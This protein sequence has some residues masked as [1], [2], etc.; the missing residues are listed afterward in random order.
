MNGNGERRNVNRMWWLMT[1]VILLLVV[2]YAANMVL[3]DECRTEMRRGEDRSVRVDNELRALAW[4]CAQEV[5]VP[6]L[7]TPETKLVRPI[8]LV[9]SFRDSS[10]YVG[11]HIVVPVRVGSIRENVIGWHLGKSDSPAAI[12][13]QFPNAI[14][15]KIG[16]LVW[17]EGVCRGRVDDGAER[18]SPRVRY[19]VVVVDCHVIRTG[20][21]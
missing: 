20:E 21:R 16:E 9:E 5:E 17:I 7:S 1:A 4:C 14:V 3:L 15:G 8:D 11:V 12:E 18:E 10:A 2:Q 19:K 13:F 6:R